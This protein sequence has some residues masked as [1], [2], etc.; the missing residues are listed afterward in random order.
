M[1]KRPILWIAFLVV[2]APG[3]CA[4]EPIDLACAFPRTTIAYANFA[5]PEGDSLASL[6]TELGNSL[7][8][9]LTGSLA[10]SERLSACLS[11]PTQL[12]LGL[13]DFAI[14]GKVGETSVGIDPRLLVVGEVPPDTAAE[15]AAIL[16]TLSRN[17]VPEIALLPDKIEQF[18]CSPT[19][20]A[21]LVGALGVSVPA[22]QREGRILVV[23]NRF[24]VWTNTPAYVPD[25]ARRLNAAAA[26][27]EA[28][29]ESLAASGI[30]RNQRADLSADTSDFGYLNVVECVRQASRLDAIG[31]A[32]KAVEFDRIESVGLNGRTDKDVSAPESPELSLRVRFRQGQAP[33]WL[34]PLILD[35]DQVY[36]AHIASID[37]GSAASTNLC[38]QV[39][40]A[41]L[42]E[43]LTTA[44]EKLAA[45]LDACGELASGTAE[46]KA[47]QTSIQQVLASKMLAAVKGLK[48]VQAAWLTSTSGAAFVAMFPEQDPH[49]T[50]ATL[51]PALT[52]EWQPLESVEGV[53]RFQQSGDGG[54]SQH[55]L[56]TR[57]YLAVG[58]P[59]TVSNLQV[60][61]EESKPEER[62]LIWVTGKDISHLFTPPGA[63]PK[64]LLPSL[65]SE[66]L[67][68]LALG[69][70]TLSRSEMHVS[71]RRVKNASNAES[72]PLLAALASEPRLRR[73]I[74]A[75]RTLLALVRAH[76]Q[77]GD[78]S[79]VLST[80]EAQAASLP[81]TSEEWRALCQ[82]LR[83]GEVAQGER[84]AIEIPAEHASL[85][86]FKVVIG[87]SGNAVVV[88]D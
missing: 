41:N 17:G 51:R 64:S 37:L 35:E 66:A 9:D 52:G 30:Y 75:S 80:L 32:L 33:S 63:D 55:A 48:V 36:P 20:F 47:I 40:H 57:S 60:G 79:A 45:S 81:I 50:W 77:G 54:A 84:Y 70:L 68:G 8:F 26:A 4:A 78:L 74:A 44:L 46:V 34:E 39:V 85:P 28:E 1:G 69:W 76:H 88:G 22:D 16:K 21:S 18:W 11:A 25:V 10:L 53:L 43:Q 65:L 3:L 6:T 19:L 56:V 15:T 49:A 82:H 38:V 7:S 14:K 31:K 13:T 58:H 87:E 71:F 59:E 67:D 27:S 83:T 5:L 24:V 12:S 2:L 73:L 29:E 23:A 42:P 62:N 61:W 72:T 86:A